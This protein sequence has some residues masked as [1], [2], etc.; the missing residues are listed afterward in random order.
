MLF[1]KSS[2]RRRWFSKNGQQLC[3]AIYNIFLLFL[4]AIQ[5]HQ[6]ENAID[7]V[8]SSTDDPFQEDVCRETA[9]LKLEV[10]HRG[11]VV[12]SSDNFYIPASS[13]SSP[14]YGILLS[15][16]RSKHLLISYTES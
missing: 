16:Q 6:H 7:V 11:E 2:I 9:S 4:F 8:Y 3:Q 1:V 13:S 5:R 15:N 14:S 12:G 10:T